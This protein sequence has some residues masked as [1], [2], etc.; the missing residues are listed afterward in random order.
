M[1]NQDVAAHLKL[2]AQLKQ[3]DGQSSFRSRAYEAAAQSV[4][5]LE[6]AD[7]DVATYPIDQIKGVGKNGSIQEVIKEYLA[8][9]TSAKYQ[10]LAMQHPVE[11]LSMTVVNGI[12]AKKAL[13]LWQQGIKNFTDLSAIAYAGGL[14][15]KLREAVLIAA[16]ATGRVPYEIAKSLAEEVLAKV[17]SIPNISRADI[18]GS[19]RRQSKTCKD[20]DIVACLKEPSLR[21][22]TMEQMRGIGS[23]FISGEKKS[24]F[25]YGANQMQVDVWLGEESYYGAL[26]GYATGSKAHNIRLRAMAN[27]RDL[28][29]NEYGIW[30]GDVRIGGEREEDLYRILGIPFVQPEE[31][32]E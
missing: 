14:D 20:I 26:L 6:Y 9:G 12:G 16:A 29:V 17:K 15:A 2:I 27:E 8:T 7:C 21:Q 25:R 24:S 19:V 23:V 31:R 11:C 10:E 5:D 3:L 22:A 1:H 18:A 4:I 28:L 32:N 30:K 13:K